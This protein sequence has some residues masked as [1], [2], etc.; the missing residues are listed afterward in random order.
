MGKKIS[1]SATNRLLEED[2][3]ESSQGELNKHEEGGREREGGAG[4]EE[5]DGERH[6]DGPHYYCGVGQCRPKW[7]QLFAKANF[8]TFL[9][10]LNSLVE[11]AIVSGKCKNRSFLTGI[12]VCYTESL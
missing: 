12:K 6:L 9:L 2:V 10:C 7:I 3:L 8:F 11:G 5:E 4:Q 1:A